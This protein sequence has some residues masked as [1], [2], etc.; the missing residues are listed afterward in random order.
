MELRFKSTEQDLTGP[1]SE[2]LGLDF[3]SWEAEEAGLEP[4][5]QLIHSFNCSTTD[6]FIPSFIQTP[7]TCQAPLLALRMAWTG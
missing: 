7:P 4:L 5:N 3:S 1:G 6:M 2:P